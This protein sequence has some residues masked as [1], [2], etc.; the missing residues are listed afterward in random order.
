M[1]KLIRLMLI[2]LLLSACGSFGNYVLDVG[3][4]VRTQR[5]FFQYE[6][7]DAQL[8]SHSIAVGHPG[9]V[10]YVYDLETGRLVGVWDG[11]F[12]DA[13]GM[14]Q[15]RGRGAFTALGEVRFLG[16]SRPLQAEGTQADSFRGL[17]YRLDESSGA[18]IFQYSYGS[19]EVTDKVLP[20]PGNNGIQHQI[21]LSQV[22]G[23]LRYEIASA[24][25]I[26]S[27]GDG[28]YAIGDDHF[29]ISAIRGGTPRI[30]VVDGRFSLVLDVNEPVLTYSVSW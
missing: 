21:S 7:P 10:S 26:I 20:L 2:T 3:D 22:S 28:S 15:G 29:V 9:G 19:Q 30:A 6:G 23:E 16:S 27:L 24:D 5:G 18:P 17:G 12:I 13:R 14:W 11:G 8:L 4:T 1:P 25:S